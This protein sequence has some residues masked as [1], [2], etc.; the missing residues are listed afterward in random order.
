MPELPEVE[1]VRRGLEPVLSG[2]FI[3]RVTLNRMN[4]RY[5]FD[6]NMVGRLQNKQCI[7][8]RRRGKYMIMDMDD[9]SS[10]VIHLG[11]SGSFTIN[12]TEVRKHDHVIFETHNGDIIAYN[13][14]RR[15]GFMVFIETDKECDYKPFS[16]MGVEP[17]SN[18]FYDE[19]LYSKLRSRKTPIKI[20]LLDQSVV[21]GVGNIYACEALYKAGISP[22][23]QS[24]EVTKSQAGNLV[25]SVRDVLNLAI[26]SGGS[27][28]RDHRQTD[29]TMGYFQHSFDVYDREGEICPVTGGVIQRIVQAGRATFYCAEKQK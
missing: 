8:L 14:P 18:D 19:I 24:N 22:L 25:Q 13:D 11:M 17:L 27:S 10:L 1:T 2:S 4:L 15:F 29:G 6:D 9:G 12:P 26:Q 7:G 20:A 23:L 21:A 5:P 28:L 16:K 3:V